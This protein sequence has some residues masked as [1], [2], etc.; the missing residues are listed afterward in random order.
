MRRL[1]WLNIFDP[2]QPDRDYP[3]L[4]LGVRDERELVQILAQLAV[5]EGVRQLSHKQAKLTNSNV[6]L[7]CRKRVGALLLTE[8]EIAA[9]L[10]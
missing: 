7:L 10:Q 6:T 2:N 1:G 3:P 5:H 9:R 4:D 8:P